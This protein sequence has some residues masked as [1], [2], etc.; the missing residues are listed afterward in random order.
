MTRYLIMTVLLLLPALV[1]ATS[2]MPVEVSHSTA[3]HSRFEALKQPFSNGPQV[4]RA[5]LSCHTEAA[6]QLHKTTHWTWDYLHPQTGQQLGKSRVVN[7]FCGSLMD[8]YERCTSCHIGYGWKD[9]HFDFSSEENV[10]CL[11]CHDTTGTY[12]K[13]SADA[14]HPA[15]ED[16]IK[17]GKIVI[18]NNKPMKK[19]DL[20]RVAQHVGKTSRFN[21]GNCHF[22]GGGGDGVKHGDLDSSLNA[23][24]HALDVHMDANG[25]NFSCATCHTAID[26][27][28]AGSRYAGQAKDTT[29]IDIPGK[30]KGGRASCESCHGL[31]PHPSTV[32]NKL[33]DHV[34][35]VA[36]Q[37]CHIPAFARGGVATK[38]LWDWSQATEKLKTDADGKRLLNEKGK[39]IRI[40]EKDEHGH[41]SYMSHKGRFEHGENVIPE[42]HWYDGEV[43]YTLLDNE[44]DPDK[45]V[46][47]NR[48]HGRYEDDD[49]R[50]WPFKRM[51][52]KQPYDKKYNRLLA[53]KVYGPDTDTALWTNYNWPK[54]LKA[55]QAEAVKAGI[56]EHEFSGDYGFVDNEMYWPITHMVAPAEDALQCAECHAR[57]GRL[58]NLAG[59]YMPG[60]DHFEELDLVALLFIGLTLAGVLLHLLIR[61]MIGIRG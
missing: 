19:V 26:H 46:S 8:N 28:V 58:A 43:E 14:G 11:V 54:A 51:V 37:T 21:C 45:V 35:K 2:E 57:E 44:I 55:G 25:L 15:Y 41:P 34:D 36:C 18:E 5:C 38:T 60:R 39:P 10:D 27:D 29:G 32:N 31:Q 52:G 3:D 61:I 49:A 33:N 48:I 7:V 6:S 40:V 56:A 4:T 9:Q 22:Y 30:S 16:K 17:N 59:F 50:I 13:P 24:S 23:P 42:Y 20:N 47:V 1:T 12:V 53:T